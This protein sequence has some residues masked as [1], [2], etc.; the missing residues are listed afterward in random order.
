MPITE[1]RLKTGT[2]TLGTDP[3]DVSVATQA[4]NV[5]LDPS[6]DEDGDRLEV[7]SGDTISPDEVETWV[8]HIEAVQDFDDPDGFVRYCFANAGDDVAYSW[9]PNAAGPTFTGTVRI[10]AAQIGG[11]VAARLATEVEFPCNERPTITDPA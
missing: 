11:D 10:R 5:S 4:T 8:L 3:A 7:L 1:S 2:L 9:K 6:V